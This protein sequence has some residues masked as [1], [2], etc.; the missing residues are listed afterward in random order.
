MSWQ[1]VA[2]ALCLLL[3]TGSVMPSTKPAVA[4]V[5][6]PFYL[7]ASFTPHWGQAADRQATSRHHFAWQ[8]L[9]QRRQTL[10]PQ[11][12]RGRIVIVDFFFSGC[13]DVCPLKTAQLARLQRQLAATPDVLLLSHSVT[14]E[15]DT[16]PDLARFGERHGVAHA[17]WR[18]LTGAR[19]TL[20]RLARETY[21]VAATSPGQALA[22]RNVHSERVLLLDQAGRIRGLYNGADAAEMRR[23]LA[24]VHLLRSGV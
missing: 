4:G 20:E 10:R 3:L 23:L 18:L 17:Q 12:L 22:E 13:S 7:D 19:A 9:D 14:P 1:V 15:L 21:L 2:S 16:P 8:L 5:D 6:L 24:D 11:D